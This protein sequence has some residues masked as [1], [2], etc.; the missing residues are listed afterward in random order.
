MV[1]SAQEMKEMRVSFLFPTIA[2]LLSIVFG[3]PLCSSVLGPEY[4]YLFKHPILD[5][6]NP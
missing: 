2:F 4:D 6:L 1:E 3:F 5:E